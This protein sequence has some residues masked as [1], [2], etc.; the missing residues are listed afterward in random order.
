MP[1]AAMTLRF[2]PGPRIGPALRQF[3]VPYLPLAV[4]ASL[5]CALIIVIVALAAAWHVAPQKTYVVNLV[6]AVAAVGR[7][8]DPPTRP[9]ETAPPPKPRELP[10]ARERTAARELPPARDLPPAKDLPPARSANVL[11]EREMSQ[12]RA[13]L[14]RP[15]DKELPTVVPPPPPRP[16]PTPAATTPAASPPAPPPPPPPQG[17]ATG[18][19]QG[20]GTM[21]LSVS[22]FPYAWYIQAVH[23]KI[24]ER[25]EGRAIQGRQ[26][27][28][29]FEIASDGQLRGAKVGKTSGNAAYDQLALRAVIEANPF[30][31]L[32]EG[33]PKSQLTIGLQFI[34]DAR[35]R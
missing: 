26:P 14:P 16:T 10:P 19:P 4:S 33:F 6:P 25:W 27:E 15:G 22:D 23:R 20:A 32:P 7:P 12:R 9:T 17:Q 13:A 21:T 29:I 24:Q 18:S 1:T 28:I 5:H 31:R 3:E 34:Y 11:P 35:A 30:P 2:R 8:V